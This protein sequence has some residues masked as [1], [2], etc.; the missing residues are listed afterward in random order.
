[1]KNNKTNR[2]GSWYNIVPATNSKPGATISNI[3]IISFL[4]IKISKAFATIA[5]AFFYLG[6]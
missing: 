5:N 4:I 2:P 3:L 1:L 6:G